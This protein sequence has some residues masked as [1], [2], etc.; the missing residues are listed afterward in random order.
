MDRI[1][2]ACGNDCGSCPRYLPKTDDELRRTAE[3]WEKI[4]YRDHIVT[5]E[6]ISCNGCTP[7]NWCRYKIVCCAAERKIDNCGECPDY[8]CVK[9]LSC[10][11][12]T[13]AFAPAC[14]KACGRDEYET[15]RKAFFCKR[16]NLD[17]IRG[18]VMTDIKAWLELFEKALHNTFG[19]RIWF[20][21]LQGSYAR[22]EASEN[23]D[24]DI[25]VILNE[26]TSADIQKYNDMLDT[27]S[28]RELICGF[29]SGV[30]EILHWEASDLFQFYYDTKPIQ[31]SLDI[32]LERIDNAA[33]ERAVK[34]GVCNIYHGCV[35]NMLHE[36]SNEILYGLYKSASFV[37][38]AICFMKT[39]K[40]TSNLKD[41]ISASDEQERNILKTFIY[42]KNK[43][44]IDFSEMSDTL[45]EWSKQ[46]MGNG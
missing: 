19:S 39:G 37:I 26:L 36:K 42:L 7:E 1:L 30:D 41:L 33:V 6:E 22:G 17:K 18:E 24:I 3:L 12:A 15:L 43:G 29:I 28:C 5:N 13:D 14:R 4:G 2:A 20:V 46:T 9:I 35:H 44:D 34:I 32:L 45:F 25:V 10:F 31:G 23:S 8:P 21:G 16:E 40:Y 27:L 11:K 38:R